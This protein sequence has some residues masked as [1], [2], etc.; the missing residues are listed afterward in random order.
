[1]VSWKFFLSNGQFI[2]HIAESEEESLRISDC[3]LDNDEFLY[4][5]GKEINHYIN[6]S[7]IICVQTEPVTTTQ[8]ESNLVLEKAA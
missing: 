3:I 5:P 1:M 8:A 7:S 2:G 6:L 4:L